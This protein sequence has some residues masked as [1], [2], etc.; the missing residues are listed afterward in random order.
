[1]APKLHFFFSPGSCALG[2]HILLHEANLAFAFTK[3]DVIAGFPDEYRHL[4]PK[5]RVPILHLDDETVTE[6]PAITTVIAQLSPSNKLLGSTPFETVR[7]YEWMN[8]MSSSLHGVAYGGVFRPHWFV[9]GEE[10]YGMVQKKSLKRVE[11]SYEYIEEKL[12][13]RKWAVGED[14]TA[15]DANL[16]VFYRW[17]TANGFKMEEKF[18]NYARIA[19]EVATRPSVIKAAEEE[20]IEL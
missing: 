1:M 3:I 10:L 12:E 17:G 16:F 15:V 19:K 13:G 2:P 8:W 14:F 6:V 7:C 5:G 11:E 18:P 4:N 20:G 9:D